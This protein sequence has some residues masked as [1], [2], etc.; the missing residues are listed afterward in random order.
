VASRDELGF[1][2]V[3]LVDEVAY[4]LPVGRRCVRKRCALAGAV[5]WQ[6]IGQSP[7]NHDDG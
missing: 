4:L 2:E 7:R 5:G 3:Y 6:E 1:L